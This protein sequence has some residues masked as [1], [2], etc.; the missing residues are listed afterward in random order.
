M[1]ETFSQ[2]YLACRESIYLNCWIWSFIHQALFFFAELAIKLF[3]WIS[4][5]SR[6]CS[7]H[8][9]NKKM[10]F[11][12]CAHHVD[13]E[14]RVLM[15]SKFVSNSI[16]RFM[17]LPNDRCVRVPFGGFSSH[18]RLSSYYYFAS[19]MSICWSPCFYFFVVGWILLMSYTAGTR[20]MIQNRKRLRSVVLNKKNTFL[21]DIYFCIILRSPVFLVW[22]ICEIW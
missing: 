9:V 21:V 20:V 22:Y 12:C 14:S 5:L 19:L 13:M 8:P 11:P 2:L 16:F 7:S 18:H 4:P 15:C 17:P 10:I 6:C 3:I 1:V